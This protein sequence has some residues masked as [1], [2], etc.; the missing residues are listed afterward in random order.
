MD[1]T[2]V[3]ELD[4]TFNDIM[5]P[6]FQYKD[7]KVKYFG[8]NEGWLKD[9]KVVDL[10]QEIDKLDNKISNAEEFW[11]LRGNKPKAE[12]TKAIYVEMQNYMRN[13]PEYYGCFS[14]Q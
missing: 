7:D 14:E 12:T 10:K 13:H 3:Y 9:M 11:W 4:Y 1:N 2:I 5:D 8:A 6:N